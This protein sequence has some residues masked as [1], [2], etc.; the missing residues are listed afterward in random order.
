MLTW[1]VCRT[2]SRLLSKSHFHFVLEPDFM[3]NNAFLSIQKNYFFL[4]N[5]LVSHFMY[6]AEL[7]QRLMKVIFEFGCQVKSGIGFKY[8]FHGIKVLLSSPSR[9]WID[10]SPLRDE[11]KDSCPYVDRFWEIRLFWVEIWPETKPAET[12]SD[13][14]NRTEL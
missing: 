13:L 11:V 14:R 6:S 2:S 7:A 9:F 12:S 8:R 1:K 10:G 3:R 5:L 4:W